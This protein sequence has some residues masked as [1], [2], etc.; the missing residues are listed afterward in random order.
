MNLTISGGNLGTVSQLVVLSNFNM[1]SDP[2]IGISNFTVNANSITATLNITPTAVIGHHNLLLMTPGGPLDSQAF[3]Q[4][5]AANG[6]FITR[7]SPES[8]AVGSATNPVTITGSNLGSVTGIKFVSLAGTP[9]ND[10]LVTGFTGGAT[11]LL[12]NLSL[13][14]NNNMV[15]GPRGLVLM[16]AGGDIQTQFTFGATSGTAPNTLNPSF[17]FPNTGVQ[18]ATNMTLRV[19]DDLPEVTG[20]EFHL[21][22]NNDPNITVNSFGQQ[23]VNITIAANAAVGPRTLVLKKNAVAI[24]TVLIFKVL[25]SGAAG[26]PTLAACNPSSGTHGS[27]GPALCTGTGFVVGATSLAFSGTGAII[28]SINVLTATSLEAH[29]TLG[30]ALGTRV[31]TVTTPTGTSGGFN[32]T[33][34]PDLVTGTTVFTGVVTAG[35]A[36]VSGSTNGASTVALFNNPEGIW[37]DGPTLYIADSLNNSLRKMDFITGQVA[38]LNT[39]TLNNPKGVWTNQYMAYVADAGSH[40]IKGV[41]LTTGAVTTLAGTGV[42]GTVNGIGT[43]A[44]FSNPTAVWGD[45]PNLYVADTGNHVI[46]KIVIDTQVVTTLAGTMSTSGS[47]N[48]VVGTGKLNGPQGLVGDGNFLWISDAGNHTIRK[49]DVATGAVASFVGTTANPGSTDGAAAGVLVSG[50]RGIWMDGNYLFLA[51]TGNGKVRRIRVDNGFTDSLTTG[52]FS[53]NAPTGIWSDGQVIYVS[54]RSNHIIAKLKP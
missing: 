53:L 6:L 49:I 24:P 45:G 33:V 52:A 50:P 29:W 15:I 37:S 28:N 23:G 44:S 13:A 47:T 38:N 2:G 5:L 34:I 4:V 43:A 36:T 14:G 1:S 51:D 21:N 32:F 48:G 18:G 11:S 3:F 12:A 41:N 17:V 30:G 19:G 7:V 27:T 54:N 26:L 22:G 40:S 20:I 39:T 25:A 16:T 10:I 31:I 46:R 9:D 8:A 42:A 35:T